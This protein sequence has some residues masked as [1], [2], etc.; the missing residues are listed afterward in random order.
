MLYLINF[1]LGY[2]LIRVTSPTPERFLNLLAKKNIPFWNLEKVDFDTLT[3]C[4]SAANFMKIRQIARRSMCKIH[5][6]KKTGFPF[7][8][9]RFKKRIT[10]TVSFMLFFALLSVLTFFIWTIDVSGCNNV[11]EALLREHLAYNGVKIGAYSKN[12]DYDDLKNDILLSIPDLVN[13]TININGTHADIQVHE[14][15]YA[16]EISDNKLPSNIISDV[17]GII[18]KI[19][20]SSGTPEVSVGDAVTRG[21]LLVSGYMTGRTGTIVGMRAIA[22]IR[23][24]TWHNFKIAATEKRTQKFETGEKKTYYTLIFGNSRINLHIKGSNL[25]TKYDKIIKKARL[26]L[27]FNIVLPIALEKQTLIEYETQDVLNSPDAFSNRAQNEI[28]NL[29][30]LNEGDTYTLKNSSLSCVRGQLCADLT[31]ECERKIGV[32]QMIPKGE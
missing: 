31:V 13:I 2:V 20:V 14:R 9:M 6:I 1:F 21:T 27:P 17:D 4:L 8:M 7:F 26:T 24:K 22:D 16:P 18:S 10:L 28:E 3:I 19:T 15:T 30:L 32:E 23:A 11:S 25:Y 29:I 5:I 12:I